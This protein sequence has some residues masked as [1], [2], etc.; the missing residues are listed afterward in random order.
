MTDNE[1]IK[2]LECCTSEGFVCS[3]CPYD[4]LEAQGV[5]YTEYDCSW[6]LRAD[7]LDLIERQKAEIE[8]LKD[9]KDN[10]IKTILSRHMQSARLIFSKSLL[11]S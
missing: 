1:I 11:K 5:E 4:T 6:Y 8:R 3:G 9:E 2:A 10:L 7:A